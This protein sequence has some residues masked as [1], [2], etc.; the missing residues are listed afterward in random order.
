MGVSSKYTK[1][2]QAAPG[3]MA[4]IM[5]ANEGS[6]GADGRDVTRWTAAASVAARV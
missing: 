3:V 2:P 1:K 5:Y 6:G 4:N